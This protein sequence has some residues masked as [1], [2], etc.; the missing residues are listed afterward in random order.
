MH[1]AAA[2]SRPYQSHHPKTLSDGF[3]HFA[4]IAY[5]LHSP[6]NQELIGSVVFLS[7]RPYH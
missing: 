3:Y 4:T 7:P 1:L 5:A 2:E 6:A